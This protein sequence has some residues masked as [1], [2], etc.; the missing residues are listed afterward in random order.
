MIVR[1]QFYQGKL[2][3]ISRYELIYLRV[4]LLLTTLSYRH[5]QKLHS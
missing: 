2:D 1:I 3:Y 4:T 5:A